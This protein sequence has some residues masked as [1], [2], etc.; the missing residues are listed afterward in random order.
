M[1]RP[2]SILTIERLR[3]AM[4]LVE[5]IN[6]NWGCVVNELHC[7][8]AVTYITVFPGMDRPRRDPMDPY[9]AW[10]RLVKLV[11]ALEIGMAGVHMARLER[12]GF[13]FVLE[14]RFP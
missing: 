2:T 14:A 9:E 11:G 10:L 8:G 1:K 13:S 3:V 4:D 5:Q 6:Q 12:N 7:S